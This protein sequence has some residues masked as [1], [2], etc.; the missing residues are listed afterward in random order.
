LHKLKYFIIPV[1][2]GIIFYSCEKQSDV[3]I[4]PVLHFPS[5]TA[6]YFT[7][8][9]FNSDTLSITL[10]ASV[11]SD[12]P[13]QKVEVKL[14]G[15]FNNIIASVE[16]KDN[17]VFPDTAAGDGKYTAILNYIFSC[18]EVGLHKLEFIAVTQNG[19]SSNPIQNQIQIIQNPN[20]PPVVSDL[21]VMPD[22][23]ASNQGTFFIFQITAIDPNGSCDIARVFYTGF[24]PNG[25]PLTPRDL[26]DDGSCCLLPPFNTASGDSVANDSKFTRVFFGSTNQ[27]G[28]FRYFLKAVDRSG[29]TSN[30]LSDS[31]LVY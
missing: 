13:I 18:R 12:D 28:Y 23:V 19:L 2:I 14:F 26:Y 4:D 29:D 15:L 27:T 8:Q 17:G 1:F 24:A 7:P 9:V 20:A 25:S 21:I 6:N 31:I 5:I 22:S 10:G 16:L 3:V 11:Q 30:I